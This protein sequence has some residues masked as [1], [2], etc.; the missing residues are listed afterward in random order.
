MNWFRILLV[1]YY[2]EVGYNKTNYAFKLLALFGLTS[3]MLKATFVAAFIYS[4]FCYV[5]GRWWCAKKLQDIENDIAND[6]NPFQKE[7]RH[8]MKNKKFKKM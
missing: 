7:V 3:Q 4:I 1:K 2:F 5:F 6:F 8:Y